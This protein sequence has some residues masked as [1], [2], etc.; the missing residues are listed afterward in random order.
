MDIITKKEQKAKQ[1][2]KQQQSKNL[3]EHCENW[4]IPGKKI[5]YKKQTNKPNIL[6]NANKPKTQQT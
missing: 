4:I 3:I 2:N 5:N 1:T 6:Y